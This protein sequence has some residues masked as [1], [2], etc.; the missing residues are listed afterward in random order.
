M[1]CLA[2]GNHRIESKI[3]NLMLLVA[4]CCV[5]RDHFRL[6]RATVYAIQNNKLNVQYFGRC[7]SFIRLTTCLLFSICI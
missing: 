5:A 6:S 1:Q 7:Y 2:D 3:Q 4:A